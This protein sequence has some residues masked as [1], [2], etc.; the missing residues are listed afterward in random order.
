MTFVTDLAHRS[1]YLVIVKVQLIPF[2]IALANGSVGDS[3]RP[4]GEDHCI[5][6]SSESFYGFV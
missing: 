2:N 5:S 1:M 3:L 4:Q 6:I